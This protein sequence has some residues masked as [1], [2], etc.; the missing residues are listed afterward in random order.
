MNTP[1]TREYKINIDPRILEL[2]GPSLYT[3]IYYV[4]AEL[5][6][7]A[8]DANAH[9]VYIIEKKNQIIVED[10]GK[11]M[12]YK[13][14]DIAKYLNVAAETR[15]TEKDVY[16]EGSNH[17]R[18]RIG[19]KGIGKLAALAVSDPV[20]VK[21]IKNGEKSGFI[22]S[23]HIGRDHKLEP[24]NERDIK[25]EKGNIK[26]GTSVVMTNPQYD[27]H[28]TPVA[29]KNNLLKIFPLVNSDF[30][31]HIKTGNTSITIKSFDAEI[32]DGLGALITFSKEFQ[33]LARHFNPAVPKR[34]A[35]SKKL[36]KKEE[37]IVIPL[38]LKNK[39]GKSENY[40]LEIKGWI[41]AYRTTKD[42]KIDRNDFPDN[43]ISLLSNGKLGE[44]N[45]LP[46]VGK[47]KL[48]E[49]YVV[50]QLHV[51]LFEETEL[52]DM[53][54]SNRQ[55]Y[56]SDD[57]RYVE[58]IK[59]VSNTLLPEIVNM[60]NTWG[61]YNR[62]EK[63]KA[64][65]ERQKKME[66]E[67]RERVDNYKTKASDRA[68]EKIAGRSENKKDIKEIIHGELNALLPIVGLKGR[69]DSQKKRILISHFGLDKPLADVICKMLVFN[70]VPYDDI[71]YTN[72]DNGESR[73]PEGENI[74][75][76][77]RQFF[78]DSYS[79]EK[80]FV[81]YVTSADMARS[82][83]AVTEVG[84]GWITR[85]SHKVFNIH[86]YR[87]QKPL[88][89]DAEW[90]TSKVKGGAITM[91]TRE[92]DKFIVKILDVCKRL[93]YKVRSEKENKTELKRYVSV[94]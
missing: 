88:D 71:I 10:D 65:E 18:K 53:A 44:Y 2:L 7:N 30:K 81:I 93:G 24:L 43:F 8:Y 47:N 17:K 85:S 14:G 46:I 28:K 41:G 67:L 77:L 79:N 74:F 15:T 78:V 82:W 58:V 70:N 64:K 83:F 31:I 72:S 48:P 22:L 90:Q 94:M 87:P 25:F 4:L 62:K 36:L 35:A 40:N 26:N 39:S 54:L 3:N 51:N 49:V 61:D 73:I 63:D 29:I 56:K 55:G 37:A 52:P 1:D 89:T 59:Y 12:S 92:F 60:R 23:R 16:V 13:D 27:L 50:G 45:I 42:R 33:Y 6:A 21:T 32:I 57:P 80:I 34:D 9:N 68:A 19:R 5:I 75:D 38:K 84:A 69:I 20:F 86:D 66:A 91:N 76:Y 11:G